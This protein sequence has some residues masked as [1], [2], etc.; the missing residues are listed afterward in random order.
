LKVADRRLG[1]VAIFATAAA[2]AYLAQGP[3]SPS[4]AHY[5]LVKSLAQGTAVIDET[6][7]QTGE[8][9]AYD[10]SY[11]EGHY[12]ANKAPGLAFV[13]LPA[14][15]ALDAVGVRSG[16]DPDPMLWALGVVGA[17]LPATL[18]LLLVRAVGERF[19]P[20]F[21]TAAAVTLGLGTLLT[22][23]AAVFFPH[24]LSAFL[25]FAAFAL[26]LTERRGAPRLLLVGGAG[27]VT[28][29]AITTEYHNVFG[30]LVLGLYALA[31]AR[32]LERGL[33]Y[34]AGSMT[35]L[36]YEGAVLKTGT[37]GHDVQLQVDEA[38]GVPHFSTLVSLLLSRWGLLTAAPVLALGVAGAVLLYR[39]GNRAEAL[40][41][42]GIGSAY[43]VYNA[44]FFDPF[45]SVPPG[46]R[47]LLPLLP[48]V[49]AP[50]ALAYRAFPLPSAVLASG[51]VSLACA[52]TATRPHIAWDG[53]VLFRLAHPS[54]WSPTLADLLGIGAWYRV[55]PLLAAFGVALAC[56]VLA[57]PWPSPARR[58]LLGAG[59][60]FAGWIAVA[61]QGWRLLE[62]KGLGRPFGPLLL[63]CGVLLLA[64]AVALLLRP[65]NL[66]RSR[67]KRRRARR[68]RSSSRLRPPR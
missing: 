5:A 62:S 65:R 37:S 48:F 14:Y 25:V 38:L 34:A 6:R 7:Y 64:A 57:T 16:G 60:A 20:G 28:G 61:T 1:L 8:Q 15:L 47:Y 26:L 23:F 68:A 33:V 59:L 51:S 39:R 24:A 58:E 21:G 29:Y 18:L 2:F 40:V 41:V 45:G 66:S 19:E 43:V 3:S 4:L 10:I 17:V 44:A 53:D 50:L 32:W 49:A 42:A 35:H 11:F 56:A 9:Q 22:T 36:S 54:W 13:V 27:L 12:Y 30:A 31:R 46:P 67:S 63:L 52:V 55:L